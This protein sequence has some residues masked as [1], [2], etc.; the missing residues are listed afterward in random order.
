MK[1]SL[2]AV[3][4]V[5]VI[6]VLTFAQTNPEDTRP[7][8][9][10]NGRQLNEQESRDFLSKIGGIG[11]TIAPVTNGVQVMSVISD[12]PASE[13]GMKT[14]DVV[15]HID[16]K[17]I[18]GLKLE[19]I[20]KRLRGAPGSKVELLVTRA[21]QPEPIVMKLVRREIVIHRD[22]PNLEAGMQR[23]EE[24]PPDYQGAF[25]LDQQGR[26]IIGEPFEK[27]SPPKAFAKIEAKQVVLASGEVLNVK[28]VFQFPRNER[29]TVAAPSIS[30]GFQG[31]AYDWSLSKPMGVN[32]HRPLGDVFVRQ[33]SQGTNDVKLFILAKESR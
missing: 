15:T 29:A 30:V 11:I 16:S 22:L 25:L 27:L 2:L 1:T 9:I 24:I 20:V 23:L 13:A 12:T 4:A 5:T 32:N 7:P 26:G 21:G 10:V 19:E 17:A 18:E 33:S 14:G 28:S 31:Q 3:I 6:S 8:I